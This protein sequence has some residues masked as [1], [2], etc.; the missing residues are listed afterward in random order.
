VRKLAIAVVLCGCLVGLAA[1]GRGKRTLTEDLAEPLGNATCAKLEVNAGDGHLTVDG[2]NGGEPLLVGGT[3]QY[4]EDQGAP[5]WSV[6]SLLEETTFTLEAAQA[7]RQGP[8]LPWA[9]CN[10]LTEWSLHLNPDVSYDITALSNG[11][12]LQLDLASLTVTRLVAG[13]GGG[14][15]E[16]TLPEDAGGLSVT[17]ETGAGNVGVSIPANVVA[18]IHASTGL[19]KVE[20]DSRFTSTGNGTYQS[21][22]YDG[23]ASVLELTVSTGAGNVT[24]SSR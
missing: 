23:A 18:R 1:C 10:G 5:T 24:I 16:I 15:I 6:S 4:Q 3:L 20:V 13:T 9:G 11:G 12:H 22:G 19:G 17:A 7:R 2:L 21:V 14:D 8:R